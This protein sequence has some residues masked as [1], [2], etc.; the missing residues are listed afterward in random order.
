MFITKPLKSFFTLIELL[1]VIAI[2]AI[3]ASMLLPALNK[4]REKARAI[5]CINK[6]KQLVQYLLMYADENMDALP[7]VTKNRVQLAEWNWATTISATFKLSGANFMCPSLREHASPWNAVAQNPDAAAQDGNFS[8]VN[9]SF[10]RSIS[11]AK[12]D[13]TLIGVE[14]FLPGFVAP[15]KTIMIFDAYCAAL[16]NRGYFSGSEAY[17]T[18]AV[19]MGEV[20]ARHGGA[21]NAGFADGHAE[22]KK[23]PCNMIRPYSTSNNPYIS[24]FFSGTSNS[25]VWN[26]LKR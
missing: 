7:H 15:S 9:Y 14:S 22:S 24:G 26:P 20:D 25:I 16:P 8:Y 21:C 5:T 2:I 4:A 3:L 10:N 18:G 11:R 23:T 12:N 13:P 1:V 17:N 6:Q 19:Y